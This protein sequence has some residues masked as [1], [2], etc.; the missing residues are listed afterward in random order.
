MLRI[1]LLVFSVSLIATPSQADSYLNPIGGP[2]GI[3]FIAPCP[4]RQVLTGLEIRWGHDV[5]SIRPLCATAQGSAASEPAPAGDL[6]YGGAGGSFTSRIVCPAA[7][8]V[9]TGMWILAEGSKTKVV[10]DIR[11]YCGHTDGR[12]IAKKEPDAVFDAPYL[13]HTGIG[14]GPD[15]GSSIADRQD[16]PNGLLAVGVH[17][18]AGELLDAVGL[19]CGAPRRTVTTLGKRKTTDKNGVTIGKRKVPLVGPILIGGTAS[20]A[21]PAPSPAS[22]L[23]AP[24]IL[25]ALHSEQGLLWNRHGGAAAGDGGQWAEPKRIGTGAG[26]VRLFSGGD[27]FYALREDGSLVWMRHRGAAD[28]SARWDSPISLGPDWDGYAHVAPADEGFVYTVSD[29]GIVHLHQNSGWAEGT[30]QWNEPIRVAQNWKGVRR[31]FSGGDRV[32]YAVM[33]DGRLIWRRHDG[34]DEGTNAW[35]GPREIGSGWQSFTDVFSPGGG[36]I[37]AVKPDTGDLVWY[38]YLGHESGE[39]TNW[40]GP[41]KV[42]DG[43]GSV[44]SVA[45]LHAQ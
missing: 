37:Y 38:R 2:G 4:D 40:E 25:Y 29:D 33:D 10:N 35:T 28:G 13:R 23:S 12:Q 24:A 30:A 16:C 11:L 1:L 14:I 18:R 21:A 15:P 43:W 34:R 26:Y 9:I 31:V 44:R 17:G 6:F 5:D 3:Q 19:I 7:T 8:P 20:P 22:I 41:V 32:L 42:N 36:V 45:A 39:G 27:D